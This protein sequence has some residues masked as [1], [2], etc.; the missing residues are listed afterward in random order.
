MEILDVAKKAPNSRRSRHTDTKTTEELSRF[1]LVYFMYIRTSDDLFIWNRTR[2][3]LHNGHRPS[4]VAR[5]L[6]EEF[7]LG[8]DQPSP[9]RDPDRDRD[10]IAYFSQLVVP[11]DAIAAPSI[12]DEGGRA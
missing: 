9:I 10:A 5:R 11:D 2:S 6:H 3:M 4:A 8:V 1:D 7:G 12:F